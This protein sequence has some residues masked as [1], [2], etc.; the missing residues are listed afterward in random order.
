MKLKRNWKKSFGRINGN[1]TPTLR[2]NFLDYMVI[3][4]NKRDPKYCAS[5]HFAS[6]IRGQQKNK[7]T[8]K[9]DTKRPDLNLVLNQVEENESTAMQC[10]L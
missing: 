9:T 3:N 7:K 10:F 5:L 2:P 1:L 6:L 4:N 8:K